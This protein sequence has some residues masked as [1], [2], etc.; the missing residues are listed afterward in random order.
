MNQLWDEAPRTPQPRYTEGECSEAVR[1]LLLLYCDDDYS[2]ESGALWQS[3]GKP[4]AGG[5]RSFPDRTFYMRAPLYYTLTVEC[6]GANT[7]IGAQ[8]WQFA[9]YRM[10]RGDAHFVVRSPEA[11]MNGLR[12]MGLLPAGWVQQPP[13]RP[14]PRLLPDN[15]AFMER[16]RGRFWDRHQDFVYPSYA[17]A[18]RPEW[19]GRRALVRPSDVPTLLAEE[20]I[21]RQRKRMVKHRRRA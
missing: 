17:A 19:V 5:T 12:Y 9:M 11:L 21:A 15:Y 16:M 7:F 6:K 14:D 1:C 8:Q 4:R 18:Y 2:H 20:E 3:D 13:R 10:Q